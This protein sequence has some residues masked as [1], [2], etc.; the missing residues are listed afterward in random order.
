M[1]VI[2]KRTE[3]DIWRQESTLSLGPNILC[4]LGSVLNF[5]MAIGSRKTWAREACGLSHDQL[6]AKRKKVNYL[7]FFFQLFILQNEKV[8]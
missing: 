8:N 7:F 4:G 2:Q 1:F 3:L 5:Q 6:F